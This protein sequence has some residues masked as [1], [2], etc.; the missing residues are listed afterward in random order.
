MIL[1]AFPEIYK[2][3]CLPVGTAGDPRL[4]D[5]VRIIVIPDIR[6]KL[7]FDP[8]EPKVAA[9]TLLRIEHYLGRHAPQLARFTV[10]NPTYIRLKVRLGVRFMPGRNPGYFR[11]ALDQELQRFLAPWAYDQSAE[12]VLGGKINA[13]LIVDF[14]ERRPYV[15]YVAGVELYTRRESGFDAQPAGD[16]T[17][18]ADAILVSERGHQIDLIAEEVFQETYFT[19]INYMEIELDFKVASDNVQ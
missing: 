18:P 4:A 11:L 12:I 9:D 5:Q 1:E 6:G 3:K 2:V 13:N 14:V 8:F 7:P 19:G 15:D 17:I 16:F 10:G